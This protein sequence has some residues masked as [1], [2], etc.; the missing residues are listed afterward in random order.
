MNDGVTF[1]LAFGVEM[2]AEAGVED[3]PRFERTITAAF[4]GIQ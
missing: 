3:R 2:R 1:D 4:D